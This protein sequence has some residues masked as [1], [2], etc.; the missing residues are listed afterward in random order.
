MSQGRDQFRWAG[1]EREK[2]KD[3]RGGAETNVLPVILGTWQL[4]FV[5][6]TG[7]GLPPIRL[8]LGTRLAP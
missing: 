5:Q 8:E 1:E 2:G 4:D 7:V 6:W 3:T